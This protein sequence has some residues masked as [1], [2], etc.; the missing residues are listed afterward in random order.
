MTQI[1]WLAEVAWKGTAILAGAFLATA[2]LRRASAAARHF[3]WTEALCALLLLP[4]V[5][6]VVPHWQVTAALLLPAARASEATRLVVRPDAPSN[7]FT[8]P[9]LFLWALGGAVAAARFVAGAVYTRRL[10]RRASPA[11]YGAAGAAE[12]ARDLGIR[13][14]VEVLESADAPVPLAC[15]LFRP[16]VVLPRGASEWPAARLVTVLRHELVHIRRWDLAAQALGQLVCCLYWFQPLAWMAA[17]KLRQER[18]RACDDAVLAAG[19]APHD[20]AAELIDLA[21]GMAGRRRSWADAPAMAEAN[22][23]EARVRGLFDRSRNRGPLGV[24][25]AIAIE[26]A[27]LAL[28]LPVA[29]LKIHAQTPGGGLA[30]VVVDPSGARVPAAKVVVQNQEG[31][32]QQT[33]ASDAAGEYRFSGLPAG[34]YTLQ[35]DMRGFKRTRINATVVAGQVSRI[36]CNL[37]VGDVSESITVTGVKP[38]TVTPNVMGTHE[39]VRIGGNVQPVQLVK[40]T[41]PAYPADLQQ[42][43]VQGIVTI[44][45]I[46]SKD[47]SVLSPKVLSTNVD[48]RLIQLALDAYKQW[49]YQ[50][51]LLNGEPIETLTKV[52]IEFT[53][54]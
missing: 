8:V 2:L 42:A 9:W 6:W 24:K 39:R 31:T 51:A 26:L 36:D 45:A 19:I 46:I 50:P 32:T 43:G 34:N 25:G 12:L 20:Y 54:N 10:V 14:K 23:L 28:L 5:M 53:L 4:A 52:D 1:S 21:R 18:E 47:G 33:L 22:D 37:S 27:V 48:Q 30:G 29:A 13:R 49:H 17:K 16:A 7:P 38:P 35:V 41:P 44:Q 11:L 40:Q 3:L 15:G